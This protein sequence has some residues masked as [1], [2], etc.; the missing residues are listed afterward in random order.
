M[1]EL[2]PSGRLIGW[3]R[4]ASSAANPSHCGGIVGARSTCL[5][6]LPET[7]LAAS[8]GPTMGAFLLGLLVM[9]VGAFLLEQ[10]VA[11]SFRLSITAER[12]DKSDDLIHCAYDVAVESSEIS[13]AKTPKNVHFLYCTFQFNP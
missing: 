7:T 8:L 6:P 1:N 10:I 11:A 13:S 2:G 3:S 12:F 4:N 9:G 5:D